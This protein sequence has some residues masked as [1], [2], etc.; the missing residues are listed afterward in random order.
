MNVIN[1]QHIGAAVAIAICGSVAIRSAS[2][3]TT[4]SGST[5]QCSA[6]SFSGDD[7]TIKSATLI[8]A[9]ATV[10]ECRV[11]GQ[12]VTSGGDVADGSAIFELDLPT[13]WNDKLLFNG[14]GGF[15]GRARKPKPQQLAQGYAT[16]STD[17]GHASTAAA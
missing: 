2:A 11:L 3:Q 16:L 14:G 5:F 7:V 4:E 15:D 12:V 17:A 10:E 8:P 9:G 1:R 13:S 6:A